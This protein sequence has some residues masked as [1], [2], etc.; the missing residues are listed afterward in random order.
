M[1]PTAV[2]RTP[3]QQ[4]SAFPPRSDIPGIIGIGGMDEIGVGMNRVHF[5]LGK[6][7]HCGFAFIHYL[8]LKI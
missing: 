6:L 5:P 1:L 8:V 2:L 7:P 4:P 3:G